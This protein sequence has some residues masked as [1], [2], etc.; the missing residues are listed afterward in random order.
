MLCDIA[1]DRLHHVFWQ[2]VDPR[3]PLYEPGNEYEDIFKRYYRFL[4][5]QVGT[6]LEL[7]PDDA[8]TMVMSDYGARPMMGG[9]CFNDWLIQENYL[10][11]AEPVSEPDADREG[12]IDWA[13]RRPGAT[14]ATTAGCS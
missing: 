5:E 14:A 8:I 6:L 11:L 10:T 7:V 4:D 3:H 1:L 13:A 9:L 12:A 2:Y